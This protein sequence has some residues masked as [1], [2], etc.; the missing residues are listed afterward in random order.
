[1]SHPFLI[2]LPLNTV[3][4]VSKLLVLLQLGLSSEFLLQDLC[5]VQ[6]VQLIVE[7]LLCHRQE[8]N[9]RD[10]VEYLKLMDNLQESPKTDKMIKNK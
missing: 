7:A 5:I 2:Q 3:S 1:M 9:V 4:I 6:P 8:W 10:L